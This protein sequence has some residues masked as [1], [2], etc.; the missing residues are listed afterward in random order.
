MVFSSFSFLFFFLPLVIILYF[1]LPYRSYRNAVL[2]V[3]SL[4][5]YAWGEP[6]YVLLM[7][8]M[9]VV[10][11]LLAKTL[12]GK[13]R[14]WIFVFTVIHNLAFLVFFKYAN[15]FMGMIAGLVGISFERFHIS[16]PIGISFYTFQILSYIVDVY[17]GNTEPQ[18]NVFYFGMYVSLFPQLIAGP[19]V[20]YVD[21]QKE[22]E[23]RQENIEDFAKGLRRF[24]FGL[25]KKIILANNVGII[26]EKAFGLENLSFTAAW[27]GMIAYALQIYFDFSAYSDM[28][29]GLGKMFG[30]HFLENFNY[31]YMA[32]SIT[33]FWRRWHISLSHW[34]RDYVYIPLGGNRKGFARQLLN[35]LLVWALTGLWHGADYNFVLWGLWF[36]FFLI[37]EKLFLGKILKKLW[38]LNRLY[39][40]MVVLFSWVIFANNSVEKIFQIFL[41]LGKIEVIN[42]YIFEE[43]SLL[44][45]LPFFVAALILVTPLYPWVEKKL[46]RFTLGSL[47]LDL[48]AL[49]LFF[50]SIFFLVNTSYNPFI[51]FRF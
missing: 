4:F 11:W 49:E 35:L 27:L 32:S 15:F 48:L 42:L 24:F 18:K 17:R 31:P 51:Y 29:I 39:T 16:L 43:L 22:I 8:Y 10:N 28:A 12:L 38:G 46:E 41:A 30:F 36:V 2:L 13:Y 40:L 50:I 20:R 33:D 19:I 44:A 25:A 7:M 34:F 45:Q 1:L 23:G 6:M 9:I 21:I 37:V 26:V 3:A 47:T 14:R 5:F